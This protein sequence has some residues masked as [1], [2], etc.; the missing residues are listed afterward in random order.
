MSYLDRIRSAEYVTPSGANF[1]FNFDDLARSGGKKASV[2]EFPGQDSASVEDLGLSSQHVPMKI[3]F[4]GKDYDQTA[5]AF[6]NSLGE[7]GPGTLR[8]P[9]FGDLS[10]LAM[11]F[12]QQ[13]RFVDG[14]GR[15]EFDIDFIIVPEREA[16]PTS[17][18]N[19]EATAVATAD[20]AAAAS[21]N[22]MA[23]S[24]VPQTAREFTESKE[25]V[26]GSVEDLA[27]WGTE[28]TASSE[29]MATAFD[30]AV[31]DF[32]NQIDILMA[33][34]VALSQA[35]IK[36]C[37]IPAQGEGS[38]LAKVSGYTVLL[39]S[40]LAF[41]PISS[42]AESIKA[43]MLS[44]LTT[45]AIDSTLNGTV[46]SR[47]EAIQAADILSEIYRDALAGLE[48]VNADR[49]TLE[50]LAEAASLA[51]KSLL[52]RSFSLESERRISLDAE[53]TPLDFV[54]EVYGD[55]DRLDEFIETNGLTGDA[56]FLIPAG[57]EVVYYG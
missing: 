30:K 5:D 31:R 43:L 25:V 11:T 38:I 4:T 3:Y 49:A 10:V 48:E 26:M 8:H 20:T 34:P 12:S 29:E 27:S 37:R 36:I 33:D 14:L 47:Q 16:F 54:F 46:R 50:A 24:F 44:G 18:V 57:R 39:E 23:E 19:M 2:H 9:R 13:E 1:V 56:L 40:T 6:W 32:E 35:Y 15:A 22:A 55:I 53:R 21:S 52:E 7:K 51:G 28:I 42:A 41:G 17:S 45:A